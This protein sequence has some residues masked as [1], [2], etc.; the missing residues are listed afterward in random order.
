MGDGRDS[1]SVIPSKQQKSFSLFILAFNFF[2][3]IKKMSK[4]NGEEASVGARNVSICDGEE[5]LLK[6][7]LRPKMSRK[8]STLAPKAKFLLAESNSLGSSQQSREPSKEVITD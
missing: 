8:W 6:K 4:A 1:Y 3:V 2:T 7:R 5:S